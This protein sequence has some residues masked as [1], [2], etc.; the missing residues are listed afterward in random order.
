MGCVEATRAKILTSEVMKTLGGYGLNEQLLVMGHH[1]REKLRSEVETQ[2][3][4]LLELW[5]NQVS[6]TGPPVLH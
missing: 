5:S 4:S 2:V 3:Q 1:E 6:S